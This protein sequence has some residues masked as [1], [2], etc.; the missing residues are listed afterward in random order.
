[1]ETS[2]KYKKRIIDMFYVS[3]EKDINKW[4][5]STFN[6][7]YHSPEYKGTEIV[8]DYEKFFKKLKIRKQ[9]DKLTIKRFSIFNS[10]KI[11]WYYRKVRKHFIDIEKNEEKMKNDKKY[12]KDVIFLKT[13]LENI[14][15][16]FHQEIRKEKLKK[17]N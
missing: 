4:E 15:N 5:K 6:H 10:I 12:N 3:V 13:N 1:M 14:E 16:N 17:L 8:I 7:E 9:G 2:K 11:W